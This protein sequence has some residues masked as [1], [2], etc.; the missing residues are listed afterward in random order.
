MLSLLSLLLFSSDMNDEYTMSHDERIIPKE[1]KTEKTRLNIR[2][3]HDM[4]RLAMCLG[5]ITLH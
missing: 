5:R 2:Q 1:T 3:T 4:Y